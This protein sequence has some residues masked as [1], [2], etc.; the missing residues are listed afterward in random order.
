[1]LCD[2]LQGRM[3]QWGR[4]DAVADLFEGRISSLTRCT[5]VDFE[6]EKIEAFYDLQLQV[7]GCSSLHASLREFV[8]EQELTGPNRYNTRRED[9]G[10]Q[11]ARRGA[12]FKRLPPVLQMHLKRF[13]YDAQTGSMR[14]LQSEFKFPTVLKLNRF[15]RSGS[16]DQPP[17]SYVL[18]GVLSHVGEMGSGHYVAYVRPLGQRQWYEFDDTRVTP[19]K[20]ETAVRRQF[21]GRHGRG[22][23]PFGMGASP[24]AYMLVYVRQDEVAKMAEAEAPSLP[25]SVRTEFEASLKRRAARGRL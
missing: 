23:G 18:Y 14:K 1:M 16:D 5:R 10:R 11:D 25:H 22:S 8:K 21:G 15:M 6:S 12:R 2:E 7:A 17:P 24:N 9:L 3:Q 20:E 13:D 19:V 4:P